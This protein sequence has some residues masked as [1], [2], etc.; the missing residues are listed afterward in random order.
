VSRH[1]AKL[2]AKRAFARALARLQLSYERAAYELDISV[3]R[4]RLLVSER[5]EH[6][7]VVPSAA[8]LVCASD[9]LLAVMLLE[10]RV[11]RAPRPEEPVEAIATRA[12]L[13]KSRTVAL[14]GAALADGHVSGPELA[15]IANS[16]ASEESATSAL[17]A[18]LRRAA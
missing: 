12:L 16:A 1:V 8:D 17:L 14:L 4:V 15:E 2:A 9:E 11:L 3:S 6:R 18:C 10:L 13:A 7:D 5:E